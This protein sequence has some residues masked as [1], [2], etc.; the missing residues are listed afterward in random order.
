MKNLITAINM[1]TKTRIPRLIIYLSMLILAASCT[2]KESRIGCPCI[3]NLDYAAIR[4]DQRIQGRPDS[5]LVTVQGLYNAIVRTKDYPEYHCVSVPRQTVNLNCYFGMSESRL[6]SGRSRLIIPVGED[7][8]PLFS[9]HKTLHLNEYSEEEYITPVLCNECTKVI[10]S[11]DQDYWDTSSFDYSMHVSGS[12]CGLDL[13]SGYP[14]EGEF[15]YDMDVYDS[16][17]YSFDMPRQKNRDIRIDAIE[18]GSV[19]FTISLAEELDR[20]G[21]QWSAESLPPLVV[22]NVNAQNLVVDIRI[23]DWDEAIYFNYYL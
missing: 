21:Y 13:V 14:I 12:S 9:Y 1:T 10:L 8:D 16:H 22:V 23:I 3:L 17:S 2:V 6:H 5:L 7:S 11:F 15:S 4:S 19:Q 20:A 18:K